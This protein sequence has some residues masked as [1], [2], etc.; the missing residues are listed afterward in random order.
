MSFYLGTTGNLKSVQV[1]TSGLAR[2]RTKYRST[3]VLTNGGGWARESAGSHNVYTVNW[4]FIRNEPYNEIMELVE[5]GDLIHFLDP[6][7]AV[8]NSLPPYIAQ[9]GDAARGGYRMIGYSSTTTVTETATLAPLVT[10]GP[11]RTTQYSGAT[12]APRKQIWLPVPMGSTL[13]LRGL[14]SGAARV[15]LTGIANQLASPR[16]ATL[17]MSTNGATVSD[18]QQPSGGPDGGTYFR[19]T[20]T[21]ANTTSP[22]YASLSPTGTGA[23]PVTP[24][25]V[26][27]YSTYARKSSGGP[28]LRMDVNWY[29][30]SG[31]TLSNGSGAGLTPGASWSR[32][33]QQYTV[34]AGAA[35]MRPGILWTGTALVG[36]VLDFAMAQV[37]L[38][39]VATPW[40]DGLLP[41]SNSATTSAP[42]VAA[43]AGTS[44]GVYLSVGAGADIAIRWL[45]S[46]VLP[47]DETPVWG[48][49]MPGLGHSGCRLD[50]DPAYT[51]YSAPQAIDF[52][53]LSLTLRETGAWE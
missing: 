25:Q 11:K 5:Y 29:D 49:W 18:V 10:T 1:P 42:V 28:L 8:T 50:A 37:E 38:G 43:A 52:G 24:G 4:D 39:A 16:L 41:V 47:N 21:T 34:P 51:L 46:L 12:G 23:I 45:Q 19:R 35:F 17:S 36:Q 48:N 32:F 9:G 30:A 33:T 13:W 2:T 27:T 22:M 53:A 31:A 26:W 15:Q 6:Q 40:S 3:G 20:M 7:A 44:Q 14:V